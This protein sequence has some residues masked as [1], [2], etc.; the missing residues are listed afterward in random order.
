[1]VE[2]TDLRQPQ[3]L[4]KQ[5]MQGSGLER[6][7]GAAMVELLQVKLFKCIVHLSLCQYWMM[8]WAGQ[9]KDPSSR[10]LEH[11]ISQVRKTHV[12]YLPLAWHLQ[13]YAKG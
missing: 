9:C 7:V 11:N 5:L 4:D 3:N 1:M 12:W 13:A 2:A 6:D 10:E 8:A